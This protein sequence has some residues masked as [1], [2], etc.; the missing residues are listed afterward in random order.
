MRA[1]SLRDIL[2][3]DSLSHI[4]SEVLLICPENDLAVAAVLEQIGYDINQ[5]WEYVPSRHRDMTNKIAIGYMIVGE[6]ARD[7]KYRHFLDTTDRVIVRGMSDPS[8]AREMSALQGRKNMYKGEDK[9]DDGSRAKKDDPRYYSE[10]ELLEFG[11]STGE[12]DEDNVGSGEYIEATWE[13]DVRAIKELQATHDHIR[14]G[15]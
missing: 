6:Y 11:Y 12:E 14:K 5:A 1:T 2:L 13:E 9:W 10:A 8:L 4:K 15:A 7:D 3:A